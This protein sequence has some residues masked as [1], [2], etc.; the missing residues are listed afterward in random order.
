MLASTWNFHFIVVL[1]HFSSNAFLYNYSNIALLELFQ[2]SLTCD[3]TKDFESKTNIQNF[4]LVTFNYEWD[5][6]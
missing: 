6:K 3:F 5:K 1:Y 4:K 2:L